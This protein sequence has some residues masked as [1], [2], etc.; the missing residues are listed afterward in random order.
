MRKKIA[1][2]AQF[3]A[4]G[5]AELD[6]FQ[7]S[8]LENMGIAETAFTT[9]DIGLAKQLLRHKDRINEH[10]RELRDKHFA[11]LNEGQASSHESSA[12][13]LDLL[14]HLRRINSAVTHVAFAILHQPEQDAG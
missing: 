1:L 13:H 12:I 7:R 11:R 2:Q 6:G 8:I 10:Y 4:E 14:T 5:M 3:S 9:R